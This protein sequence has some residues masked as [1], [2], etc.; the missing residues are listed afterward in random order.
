M[1][2]TFKETTHKQ[3]V[4]TLEVL[5]ATTNVPKIDQM[6][7]HVNHYVGHPQNMPIGQTNIYLMSLYHKG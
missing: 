3:Y 5:T 6:T 7:Q 1:M 2:E 4:D